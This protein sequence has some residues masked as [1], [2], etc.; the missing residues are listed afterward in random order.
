MKN[1]WLKRREEKDYWIP[2]RA[3]A[4]DIEILPGAQDLTASEKKWKR[5]E[6]LSTSGFLIFKG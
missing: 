6:I 1:Y 4:K 3:Y 5:I 2:T